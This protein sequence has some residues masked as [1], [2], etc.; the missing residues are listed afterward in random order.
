MEAMVTRPDGAG[1]LPSP[2]AVAGMMVGNT[3]LTEAPALAFKKDRRVVLVIMATLCWGLKF[4]K[5]PYARQATVTH[6]EQISHHKGTEITRRR[7]KSV[8]VAVLSDNV[9]QSARYLLFK[10]SLPSVRFLS[11]HQGRG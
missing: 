1:R 5:G 11:E 8:T 9:I 7:L 2:N 4:A 10:V 6:E 3:S